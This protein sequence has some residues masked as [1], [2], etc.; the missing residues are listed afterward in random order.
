MHFY[1]NGMI[2]VSPIGRN[3]SNQERNDYEAYDK[4]HQIRAKFVE[5]LRQKFGHFGLTYVPLPSPPLPPTL[6]AH[7]TNPPP[8]TVTLSAAKSP[9]TSSPPAGTKPTA[10]NTLKKKKALAASSTRQSTFSGTRRTRAG[11]ITRFMWIRGRWGTV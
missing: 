10:Y 1:R 4:Q 6:H 3:A 9:S 7:Y 2:N 8:P 11:M 5:A